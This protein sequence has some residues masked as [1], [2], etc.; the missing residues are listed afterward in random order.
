MSTQKPISVAN[1]LERISTSGHSSIALRAR[2]I[3]EIEHK[4]IGLLPENLASQCRVAG[5]A[6]GRLKLVCDSPAWAARVRF[7]GARLVQQLTRNGSVTVR[8]V[9]VRVLPTAENRPEPLA[10]RARM[11]AENARLLRQT[12]EAIADPNLARALARLAGRG[13]DSKR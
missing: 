6:D 3:A 4:I 12:A 2:Q 11:T 5:L 1:I 10:R 9:Q 7:Q 8:T 13:T